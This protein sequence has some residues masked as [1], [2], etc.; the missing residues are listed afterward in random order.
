MKRAVL[1]SVTVG[2]LVGS[3]LFAPAASGVGPQHANVRTQIRCAMTIQQR[4]TTWWFPQGPPKAL[5]WLQH[6]F[7]R[8]N[9]NMADL[10]GKLAG[11]GYLV[12]APDLAS[13]NVLGCTLENL[14]GN[15]NYMRNV[16]D[17][18]GKKDNTDKLSRSWAAAAAKLGRT[19]LAMPTKM[20][21]I[22]HS[23]GG[24]AVVF[25]GAQVIK[26]YPGQAPNLVGEVL[27]D[28]VPSPVGDHLATG[29]DG[30]V[31]A[32]TPIRVVA[33]APGTC[34]K[35]GEGTATLA[36]HASGFL[37]LRLTTGKHTDAE[38][39][40]TDR[41]A[42]LACGKPAAANVSALQTL[43]LAWTA[44]M[45]DGTR[46]AKYYP[47]GAY[48]EA[49]RQS[50]AATVLSGSLHIGRGVPVIKRF[51]TRLFSKKGAAVRVRLGY[52]KPRGTTITKTRLAASSR[53]R[54]VRS[55]RVV[56]LSPGR[57]RVNAVLTY[58]N[59]QGRE[60]TA[61]LSGVIRVVRRNCR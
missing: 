51:P 35:D 55:S 34:N 45:V 40:S 50:G 9:D 26:N 46:T 60:G 48:V 19:G 23:V 38:G 59:G 2:T 14:G 22:G 24:E 4:P 15:G 32:K 31:A 54:L 30:L 3:V 36:S 21:F 27:L 16:A 33:A 44:D 1:V 29:I 11:N 13:A 7:A 12:F 17:L 47:G 25:V 20:V 53:G 52:S 39:S 57:W 37:G 18:F 42:T 58:R 43:A 56:R 41:I 8:S 28:P 49:L 5:V 61:T 6:G 10:A